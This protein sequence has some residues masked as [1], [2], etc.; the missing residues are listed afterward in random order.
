MVT[1]TQEGKRNEAVL[2]VLRSESHQKK[3][4]TQS[5]KSVRTEAMECITPL[6]SRAK[7]EWGNTLVS[8][9][10]P[11]SKTIKETHCHTQPETSYYRSSLQDLAYL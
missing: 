6:S 3:A 9:S 2:P 5:S 8:F 7:E 11:T 4:E 1:I 10:F